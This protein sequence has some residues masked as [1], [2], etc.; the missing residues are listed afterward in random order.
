MFGRKKDIT[1]TQEDL[2]EI[3]RTIGEIELTTSG[4]LRVVIKTTHRPGEDEIGIMEMT[5]SE[6]N[7]LEMHKTREMTG[8]LI[9]L[10]AVQRKFCIYPDAGIRV[11]VNPPFW[12]DLSAVMSSRL[13]KN[14]P[15]EGIVYCL[16][17]VGKILSK[18]FPR[19]EDDVNELSDDVIIL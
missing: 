18:Y 12:R 1:F 17:E 19:H 13:S 14:Q 6:F 15:K 8:V 2:D 11:K 16:R 9:F 3:K 10:S 7:R 4:E 5:Q